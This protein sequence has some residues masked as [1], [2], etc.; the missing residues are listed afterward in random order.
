MSRPAHRLPYQQGASLIE[1]LVSILV[2]AFGVL[3]MAAVQSNTMKYHKTSEFRATANLL[4][5]DLA[6]RM[7][8]NQAGA[9]ANGYRWATT[10]YNT[11]PTSPPKSS[12]FGTVKSGAL[13]PC[14]ANA[15]A[16]N[17]RADWQT[18]LQLSLPQASGLIS[19]Y[20]TTTNTIELWVAWSDPGEAANLDQQSPECPGSWASTAPYH[21][22]FLRVAL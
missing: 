3:A 10:D 6:D 9:I 2:I 17:D 19:A 1:V 14:S 18:R 8:A 13:T 4:A 22:V 20:D 12:T 21:C 7:R 5:S 16:T 15:L 11:P